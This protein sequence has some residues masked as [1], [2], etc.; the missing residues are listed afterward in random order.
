MGSKTLDTLAALDPD[1][2][3]LVRGRVAPDNQG[4]WDA[5][6]HIRMRI[7]DSGWSQVFWIPRGMIVLR[8]A[9]LSMS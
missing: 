4:I 9:C 2:D 8:P 7:G 6:T 1:A 3:Y 5:G